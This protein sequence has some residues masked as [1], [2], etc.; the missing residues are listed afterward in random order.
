MARYNPNDEKQL[1][2]L[3][4]S[5]TWSKTKVLPFRESYMD[6]LRFYVGHDYGN[7]G[8]PDK[9]PVNTLRLAVDIYGRSLAA[10]NPNVLAVTFEKT[11]KSQAKMLEVAVNEL[12]REL[13]LTVTLREAVKSALFMMGVVKVGLTPPGEGRLRSPFYD[14]GE[15]YAEN[16][17][18]DDW[19]HDMTA[20]R[21]TEWDWCGNRYRV[22][23]DMV[24]ENKDYS[25]KA[26]Q[27]ISKPTG[28]GFTDDGPEENRSHTLSQGGGPLKEEYREHIELWDLWLPRDKLVITLPVEGE[29]PPLKV[30]DWEGPDLGPY[31]I[32]TFGDVPGNIMPAPPAMMW[33]DLHDLMNRL[34]VKLGRQAERQK[35][36]TFASGTAAQDKTGERVMT[37]ED[38]QVIRVDDPS[39]VR[40]AKYG[41]VD[42]GN[43]AFVIQLKELFSYLGGNLDSLG[44]LSQ[45]AETLGQEKIIRSQSSQ[46]LEELS[47]RVVNFTSNIVSDLA[48]YV[49]TDPISE[50]PLT[51]RIQGIDQDIPFTW[52]PEDRTE[53]FVKFRIKLEPYSMQAKSPAARLNAVFTILQQVV[54]P[55]AQQMQMQGL[56]VD[57]EQLLDIAAK[58]SDLPEL[59]DV[60]KSSAMDIAAMT[61][62]NGGGSGGPPDPSKPNGNY[63]RT[64]V[65]T[66]GTQQSRDGILT[67][68][69]LGGGGAQNNPAQ[70]GTIG[71]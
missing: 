14:A 23:Y 18:F 58:Y 40:E 42:P 19:L 45:Q 36:V 4:R 71:K 27:A 44:G 69:L 32:L 30:M 70:L 61:S 11:L 1:T 64:S 28:A 3:R 65:A 41:G 59:M 6:L 5:M 38:G 55:F 37:A 35:T 16:V 12:L 46:L 2:K 51:T 50:I 26:R 7:D 22:P 8:T 31:H 20:R 15:P 66:G 47:D 9:T 17:L 33:K 24:M 53:D 63:T 57:V 43:L 67:R 25:A 10:Q 62:P 54:V 49:Y 48:Y 68:Q 52:T 21:M 13:D 60:I 29:G 34:F 39:S 56:E